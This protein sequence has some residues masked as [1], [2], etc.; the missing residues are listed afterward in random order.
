MTAA[1]GAGAVAGLGTK[2][3]YLAGGA[4]GVFT[5]LDSVNKI[6]ASNNNLVIQKA[7]HGKENADNISVRPIPQG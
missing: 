5:A 1:A 4:V 3:G 2:S 6:V 7:N